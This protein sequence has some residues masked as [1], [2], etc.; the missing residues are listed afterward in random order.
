MWVK[1]K[2][3]SYRNVENGLTFGVQV[4]PE[5]LTEVPTARVYLHSLGHPAVTVQDGYR[6][7][8]DAYAALNELLTSDGFTVVELPAPYADENVPTTE[9]EEVK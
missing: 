5:P 4:V 3:G 8:E 2:T 6:T 9:D 1:L 7:E